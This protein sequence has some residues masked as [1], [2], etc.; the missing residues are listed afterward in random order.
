MCSVSARLSATLPAVQ[1]Y[2]VL[3]KDIIQQLKGRNDELDQTSGF[4]VINTSG[5]QFVSS[6]H[7][8]RE[9]SVPC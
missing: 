2:K 9:A 5:M 3:R 7:A 4:T 6:K 8:S 1:K